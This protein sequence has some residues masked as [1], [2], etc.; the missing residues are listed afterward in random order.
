VKINSAWREDSSIFSIIYRAYCGDIE[1]G[2]LSR[3]S[4]NR[5]TSIPDW[6]L[7]L[8]LEEIDI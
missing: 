5:Q 4:D 8:T 3:S 6:V 1:K 7:A 2:R